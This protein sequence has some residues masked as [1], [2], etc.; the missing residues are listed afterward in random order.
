[1]DGAT[2]VGF[3]ELLRVVKYVLDTHMY[4]LLLKPKKLTEMWNITAYT[5]SNWAG[6]KQTR[7][8]VAGYVLYFCG[9][10]VAWKSKG[11]KHV[12]L[13]L[14]EAELVALSECVKDVK[15]VMKIVEDLGL[16]LQRPVTVRVDN[17]G[18]MF[19]AENATTTQR[20]RHIDI[21]YK[22]VSEFIENGD[23]EIVFVKTAEND[24]DIFT[25]NVSGDLN[26]RHVKQMMH[27]ED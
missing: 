24:A 9:V 6:D 5:D 15:F 8:S 14:S 7:I 13:S 2:E 21:R 16:E 27:L 20:T 10:A 22:W 4:G 12:T 18:A 25:K 3:K 1:M 23:V 17:V 11:M 19:L 26:E